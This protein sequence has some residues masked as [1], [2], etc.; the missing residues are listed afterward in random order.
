MLSAGV[1]L[2]RPIYTTAPAGLP[3]TITLS[4]GSV[5]MLRPGTTLIH[6]RLPA[7]MH[8]S[9]RA[10]R[11][12]GEAFFDVA[13]TGSRFSVEAEDA[14]IEVLGT[15]FNVRAWPDERETTVTLVE[16]SVRLIPAATPSEAVV[17]T[18]NSRSRVG[19]GG[20]Q[21]ETVPVSPDAAI[22]WRD[23][24]LVYKDERLGHVLS[25]VG[26]RFG[27]RIE[28]SPELRNRRVSVSLHHPASA[29]AVM[30]DLGLSLSLRYRPLADGFE[31]YPADPTDS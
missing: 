30:R 15:R 24:Q 9:N 23:D 4:D 20:Q 25:D 19:G 18:P 6:D 12:D 21:I 27:V 29:E 16:G 22:E 10:V 8:G 28:V 5:V 1:W 11:L 2:A 7:L 13:T 26:R 3:T 17:M 14:R 31:I